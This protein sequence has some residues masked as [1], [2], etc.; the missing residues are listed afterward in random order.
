MSFKAT[1][2]K[3][4]PDRIKP[5]PRAPSPA[6]S[7][8]QSRRSST[9]TDASFHDAR[10]PAEEE[11]SML[12]ASHSVKAQANAQFAAEDFSSAIGTYDRALAELPNYL[13]YEMAV[14]QSN[15]AACHIKLEQW[16][17]AISSC[18][19]GLDGLEREMPTKSKKRPVVKGKE[20]ATTSGSKSATTQQK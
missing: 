13:D 20:K 7:P 8:P 3:T 11:A 2:P 4:R 17:E 15:I 19:K 18:Q 16:K 6:Q 5:H 10:F 14:L 9:S 12:S 1:G